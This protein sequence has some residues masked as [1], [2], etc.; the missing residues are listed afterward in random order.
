LTLNV[1]RWRGQIGLSQ[2][3]QDD[4]EKLASSLDVLGGK[5]M[6]VDMTG[7]KN[8]RKTRLMAVMV[9]REGQTWFFKLMGDATVAERERAA[10]IKF[11][12][13]ARYPNA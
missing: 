10:F 5:A 13:S 1:N 2:L 12:Q 4:A 3:A 7:D 6:L 11:V 8:G 9:P